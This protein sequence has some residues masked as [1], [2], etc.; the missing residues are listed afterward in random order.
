MKNTRLKNSVLAVA[1][2]LPLGQAGSVW[3]HDQNGSLGKSAGATD[4][5]QVSCSTDSGGDS[6]HLN[7]QVLDSAPAASPMVSVQVQ[8]GAAAANSTDPK[9]GDTAYS[10]EVSVTGGN[11]AYTV[12]VNKTASG[13]ENYALEYHCQA[14]NGNHTGTAIVPLQNQ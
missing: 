2:V 7:V 14:K 1:L 9:D 3:A 13:A 11:G 12:M 4:L 8:K 5:Y 6:D 10:P